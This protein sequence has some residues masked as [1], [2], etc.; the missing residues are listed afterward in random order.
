MKVT[1]EEVE[2]AR[3]NFKLGVYTAADGVQTYCSTW[4][5][6]VETTISECRRCDNESER[7]NNMSEDVKEEVCEGPEV[8]DGD[9]T[10]VKKDEPMNDGQLRR[11]DDAL[12]RAH[13]F[14]VALWDK[15]TVCPGCYREALSSI[16]EARAS[17]EYQHSVIDEY[18]Q[19]VDFLECENEDLRERLETLI[20][21]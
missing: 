5:E 15:Q 17:I 4:D 9:P 8:K 18:G 16:E 3:K 20:G 19:I 2:E 10:V 13:D 14:V 11:L 12:G 6:E 7:K 21:K 1:A